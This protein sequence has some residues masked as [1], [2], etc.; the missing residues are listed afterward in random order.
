M[1]MTTTPHD[2]V[3][4]T[5]L[6]HTST[7]RDF[8]QTHLPAE[9]LQYCNLQT[10]QLASGSFIEKELRALYSDVLYSM[11]AG[12]GEGYIYCLIEH[13]SSP[14]KHM[15]LRLM[16][17]ALA[18]MQRHVDQGH[19]KPPL[20]IPILFYHG[21]SSPYPYPMN[22]LQQF[23]DPELASRLYNSDFPLVDVTVIPDDV[24]K[25][26]KRGATLEFMQKHCRTQQKIDDFGE[27]L[28]MLIQSNDHTEQ[29]IKASIFYQ[30]LTRSA[31]DM[32]VLIRILTQELPQYK[33]ITM[34]FAEMMHQKGWDEG[35][36]EGRE[37]G[38]QQMQQEKLQIARTMLFEGLAPAL[39]MKVTGLTADELKYSETAMA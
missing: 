31:D 36:E 18:A 12:N 9:L 14:D 35:H 1:D 39:V 25:T 2:A 29:Q 38:R 11:K 20:V 5:F 32:Q 24:I 16:R 8:L 15:T 34:T 17:Y 3:F 13:Q 21:Q 19:D 37:E 23:D 28:L 26:H 7:A 6:T 30:M 27:K 4:K 22:W 33:E 10:L